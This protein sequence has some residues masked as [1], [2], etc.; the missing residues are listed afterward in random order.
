MRKATDLSLLSGDLLAI[1]SFKD[2]PPIL[3]KLESG[4]DDVAWVDANG[5]RGAIR[6]V[7][8]D[9]IDVDNPLFTVDL[10]DFSLATLVFSADDPDFVILSH[11]YRSCLDKRR[12]SGQDSHK[13]WDKI[14]RTAQTLYFPL[15][16]L[17]RE[18]D[19]IFL[20]TEDGAEKWALRDLRL[21]EEVSV[22]SA[23]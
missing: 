9:T 19:M 6:L 2:R 10:G 11:W 13:I 18:D 16:S 4:D 22:S 8:L 17:E 1:F 7:P 21:A 23:E 5:D 12:T 3:V 15:S 14:R 20:R